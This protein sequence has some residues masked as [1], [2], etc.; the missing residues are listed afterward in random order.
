MKKIIIL[1]IGGNCIDIL[2]T[3]N[4]INRIKKTYECVGFLDDNADKSMNICGL[5]ILGNLEDAFKYR[6]CYFVNGIGS[7]NNFWYKRDII[8]KT[9]IELN[10]FETIVHPTAS[11]SEMA[12]IGKGVVIFSNVTICSNVY[13]GNHVMILSNSVINHNDV[14]G[15]YS[16]IASGAC[17][18]GNVE[19]GENCYLGSN[20]SII[21]DIKVG[22]DVLIGMGSTVLKNVEYNTVIAGNPA[23]FIRYVHD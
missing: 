20:C 6:E 12:S 8:Y 7:T 14:I 5:K 3:I 9:K 15:D 2:D 23:H 1:G 13:I 21:N 16:I 17:L 11:V 19:I 4:E 22:K 18:S 10:R